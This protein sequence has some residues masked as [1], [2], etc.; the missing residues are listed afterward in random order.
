MKSTHLCV[1]VCVHALC[2]CT[3]ACVCSHVGHM[4]SD[5]C[6]LGCVVHTLLALVVVRA[7][8][9]VPKRGHG[10][11]WWSATCMEV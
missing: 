7:S 1:C 2:M 11:C 8:D 9:A 5:V 3:C 6:C 10:V 4:L